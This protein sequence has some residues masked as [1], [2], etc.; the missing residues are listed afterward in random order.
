MGLIEEVDRA[1]QP[2]IAKGIVIAVEPGP[3]GQDGVQNPP[4]PGV[5]VTL[6]CP[7]PE[8]HRTQIERLLQEAGLAGR[9]RLV[10]NPRSPPVLTRG[11]MPLM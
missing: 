3:N 10:L 4:R 2:L 1:L 9:V 5:S 11:R 8:S 6:D 7:D